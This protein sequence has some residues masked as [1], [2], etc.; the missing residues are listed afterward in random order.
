[1]LYV[2]R[3]ANAFEDQMMDFV[4]VLYLERRPLYL[5]G[6]KAGTA[7]VDVDCGGDLNDI[8]KR[9]AC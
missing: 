5:D 7:D 4:V 2:Q 9:T 1:M 3:Q 6:I 8:P